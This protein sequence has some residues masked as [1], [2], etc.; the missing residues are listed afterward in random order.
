MFAHWTLHNKYYTYNSTEFNNIVH[1]IAIIWVLDA[2]DLFFP[3]II[4]FY[5]GNN[6]IFLK[7]YSFT[8][9]HLLFHFAP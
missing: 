5:H 3:Y 8:E 4:V 7:E 6:I 1:D 2:R 9:G